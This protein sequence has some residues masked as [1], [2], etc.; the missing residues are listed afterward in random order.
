MPHADWPNMLADF[1]EIC[2]VVLVMTAVIAIGDYARALWVQ[3]LERDERDEP[4]T[5]DS[6]VPDV[7]FVRVNRASL[8]DGSE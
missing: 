2:I 5:P 1:G 3:W 8:S 7:T 6:T 4:A